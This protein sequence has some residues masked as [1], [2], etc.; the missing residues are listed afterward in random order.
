MF[1][2]RHDMSYGMMGCCSYD[3]A[4]SSIRSMLGAY[5][6]EA[7]EE[8]HLLLPSWAILSDKTEQEYE[9]D[10]VTPSKFVVPLFIR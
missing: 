1:D 9:I 4:M 6:D 10:F 2:V 8:I 7:F 3:S 5:K